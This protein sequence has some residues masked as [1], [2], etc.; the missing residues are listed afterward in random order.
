MQLYSKHES[1]ESTLDM[2]LWMFNENPGLLKDIEDKQNTLFDKVTTKSQLF[3]EYCEDSNLTTKAEI[4]S[5]L[6]NGVIRRS[7]D[8]YLYSDYTLGD[9]IEDA[10]AFYKNAKNSA[11]LAQMKAELKRA[12]GN[13]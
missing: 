1:N 3:I 10:V 9:T 4:Y 6:H 8:T 7:G 11:I 5:M 12:K 13:K 2:L